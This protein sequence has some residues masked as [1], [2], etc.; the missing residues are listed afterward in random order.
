MLQDK[1]VVKQPGGPGK[2]E[3]PNWEK[4]S[5]KKIRDALNQSLMRNPI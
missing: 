2:W 3:I 1:I 5:H 4:E